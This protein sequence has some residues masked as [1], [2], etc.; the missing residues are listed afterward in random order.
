LINGLI[1]Y[2]SNYNSIGGNKGNSK[3]EN[4]DDNENLGKDKDKDSGSNQV[5]K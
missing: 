4:N 5:L 1:E 2:K 3:N